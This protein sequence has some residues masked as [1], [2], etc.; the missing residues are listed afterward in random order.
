MEGKRITR[1]RLSDYARYLHQAERSPGTIENYL[2]HAEAFACWL[3][4]RPVTKEL[5]SRWKEHLLKEGYAPVFINAM[6]AAINGLFS[7][8]GWE[9]YKVKFLK[10]QRKTFRE[11]ARELTRPE[12]NRLLKAAQSQGRERLALLMEA[13]CST[14]IRV[15]EVKYLT[16]EAARAGRA[17]IRMKGKFRTILLSGR[18]CMKLLKYAKKQKTESGEIFI[19][20]NGKS[21]SRRQ[22]WEELKRLCADAKVKS[23]KVF[24]HNFRHLFAATYY[25][26]YKDIVKLA[27]V[28]GHCSI[29]TT[30]IYLAASGTEHV[31]QWNEALA[32]L[33]AAPEEMTAQLAKEQLLKLLHEKKS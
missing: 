13:L 3:D 33:F 4:H 16:V 32:Y 23:S 2:R 17:D 11:P 27:D 20:R 19:T 30:R 26:A 14:G 25:R 1:K 28:L 5:A 8:L 9:G 31:R 15:G 21:L 29:E 6:L 7:F 18:L 10:I 22:I 12:Y 24:P